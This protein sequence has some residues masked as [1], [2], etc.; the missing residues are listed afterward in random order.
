MAFEAA[1]TVLLFL[2][3]LLI[4]TKHLINRNRGNLK[5]PSPP[6]RPIIGH[7]HL[8]TNNQP[9][10]RTLFSLSQRYGPIMYLQLGCRPLLVISSSHLGKECFTTNDRIFASRPRLSAG[11]KLGYGHKILAAAPYGPY[12]RNVRKLCTLQ[13]LSAHRIESLKQVRQQEISTLVCSLYNDCRKQGRTVNMKFRLAELTFNVLARMVANK[14]CA[15]ISYS[16]NSKE[17]RQ[18][19]EMIDEAVLLLG[20][21]NVGDYLPFLKW[22]D[23]HG[24]EAAM[25]KLYKKRDAF[26]QALVDEHR[27]RRRLQPPQTQDFIDVLISAADNREIVSDDNDAVV[28]AT[29]ITM[30]NAGTETTAVTIEWALASLL[31]NPEILKKAH[32]ELDAHIGRHRVIEESDLH[33]L[34]YLQAIVKETLRLYPAGP[35]LVPHE[36]TEAC[37]I[38]GFHVPAGTRLMVNAWAIH[39]DPAVWERPTEFDP[40]RFLK[41]EREIDVKGQDFELIP[42]GSGRRMCPGMSLALCMVSYTLGRLLQSFEWSVPAATTIDM[43]EGLGLTMPKAVPLKTLIQPRLSPHI[44]EFNTFQDENIQMC[45]LA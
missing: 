12:W 25:K 33:K 19:R 16:E 41:S 38:G 5:P 3:V 35:L 27:E 20:T 28:K 23:L 7:L 21:F 43:R 26:L 37:T 9:T 2:T 11:Q 15:G 13:L 14:R 31:Q 29:A 10:H 24:L 1:V 45:K 18:F 39:R 36:S 17:A 30:L 44:Y 40:E 4:I 8:L 42:F 6:S 34:R 32:Q 22:L